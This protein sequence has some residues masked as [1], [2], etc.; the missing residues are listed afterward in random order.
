M[1]GIVVIAP[2]SSYPAPVMITKGETI[3]TGRKGTEYTGRVWITT[4]VGSQAWAPVQFLQPMAGS[5]KAVGARGCAAQDLDGLVG[6]ELTLHLAL[7]DWG[8]AEK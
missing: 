2:Q 3:A 8:W 1:N 4:R 7:N 5:L 6:D